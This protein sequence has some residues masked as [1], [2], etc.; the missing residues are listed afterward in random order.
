[1]NELKM[2][3]LNIDIKTPGIKMMCRTRLLNKKG[4]YNNFEVELIEYNEDDEYVLLKDKTNEY[5]IDLDLYKKGFKPAY[6]RTLHNVQGK[7][8]NSYYVS[9]KSALIF[10][11][12]GRATYTLISRIRQEKPINKPTDEIHNNKYDMT[13]ISFD[14][15]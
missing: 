2:K 4:L 5:K 1:M 8:I 15:L 10:A 12:S 7:T 14:S 9:D 11:E 6:A 3:S 13:K